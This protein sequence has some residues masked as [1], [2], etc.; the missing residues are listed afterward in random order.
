MAVLETIRSRMGILVSVIIGL[1]L[2]AFVLG[3][4]IGGGKS[5]LSGD[6]YEIAEISGESI[7]VNDYEEQV[8]KL[9]DVYKFQSG[10][11]NLT[12]EVIQNV[13]DQSWQQ[14]V[15]NKVLG[16]E[17]S[18][19]GLE[20]SSKEVL[21]MV[22]GAN[23]HP[24]IKQLF[25]NPDTKEFNRAAVVQFIKSLSDNSK[26]NEGRNNFW[27]YLENQIMQERRM[28]KYQNLIKKGLYI[29]S[30]QIA[31]EE[32]ASSRKVN[33]SYISE[34]YSS[35][36]D[37]LVK[38]KES[39]LKTYLK[40]H[41]KEYEQE[42]SR[43]IEFITFDIVPSPYDF[44]AAQKWINEIKP[45]YEAATEIKQF[46]NL[47]SDESFSDKFSGVNELPDTLKSLYNGKVGDTYGPYFENSTFKIARVV[48]FKDL[49]DS[50]KASHIL[51]PPKEQTKESFEQAKAL[52]DSLKKVAEK[53]GDF[54][55]LAKKYSTDGSAKNGGD[56]GWFK[57]GA[58]V[59]PFNDASFNGKKGDLVIVES[60]FGIHVINITDKGKESKK[61]KIGILER[62]VEASS[63]TEQGIYQK[64]SSFAAKYSNGDLFKE[65][66][67]KEGMAP[68]VANYLNENMKEVT[69][70]TNSREVV[71]WAFKAESNSISGVLSVGQKFVIARLSQ[72]REKGV[73]PL[74]IVK[75]QVTAMVIKD[76]KAALLIEKMRTSMN[77]VNDINSLASKTNTTVAVANDITFSSFALPQ[78]GY[79][80]SVIA[81]ITTLPINKLSVPVKGNNGVF[82]VVATEELAQQ[83]S[84][85]A[86]QNRLAS[87]IINRV[88]Y[89]VVNVLK[90]EANVID[91]RSKF[92]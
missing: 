85:D 76:K 36:A 46:I 12:D 70:L 52:A 1:A 53:G 51:I 15:D 5:A 31:A 80:P 35:I 68:Q 47:N 38:V 32:K 24:Y 77:G 81:A 20:V 88:G 25:V 86:I 57:E 43:D 79:E 83:T 23:P 16:N 13:R 62:K 89:E 37:S 7:N 71:R 34:N 30:H 63:E 40:E 69:G 78:A 45:E 66:V 50:V 56:L 10:Q 39:E 17:Y 27:L 48:E 64:A 42:A 3:D 92:Y 44:Q 19:I 11:A 8:N 49:S 91:R 28:T 2:I 84:K 54:A 73:A 18:E 90:K 21:D 6:Q 61:V 74:E 82:V 67:K 59:K 87:T 14:L 60:Q 75:D 72:V 55:E 22:Q 9:S 26:E 33:A 41:S 29:T 65:G 4:F 58:M